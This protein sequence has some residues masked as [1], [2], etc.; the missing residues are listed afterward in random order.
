MFESLC[1]SLAA[2]LIFWAIPYFYKL[3]YC[4]FIFYAEY[5][6]RVIWLNNCLRDY[7]MNL[8]SPFKLNQKLID[9]LKNIDTLSMNNVRIDYTEFKSTLK[10]LL[11]YSRE[12]QAK[13][14]LTY[15]F[16]KFFYRR[17]KRLNNFITL[18]ECS[19]QPLVDSKGNKIP[20]KIDARNKIKLL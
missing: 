3:I 12:V 19:E 16:S 5:R 18:L 9:T 17:A 14:E 6:K 15:L 10:S 20:L 11:S 2:S 1:T 13:R 7:G 8:A 4:H